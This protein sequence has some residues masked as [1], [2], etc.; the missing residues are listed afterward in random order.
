[1]PTLIQKIRKELKAAGREDVAASAERFFK[2]DICVH[3]L[4]SAEVAALAKAHFKAIKP[5][6]KAEIFA[7]CEDLWRSGYMEEA[8]IACHWSHALRKQFSPADFALFERWI[9]AYVTNWAACDTFCNH[10]VGA[11]LERFPEFLPELR[12][13]TR[14]DNRWMRRAAAVSLI[15]PAKRGLFLDEVFALAD[16]LLLDPDDLVQKGYGWLLK[17]ASHTHEQDVFEFVVARKASMPRTA[18][19]YA[20]EKLPAKLKAEAMKR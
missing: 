4:K 11:L 15:V 9:G 19:R 18:L 5:L 10:T 7:L 20:I 17:V 12:R 3:G 14:S 6:P 13:W 2:E 16:L 1:M 8:L